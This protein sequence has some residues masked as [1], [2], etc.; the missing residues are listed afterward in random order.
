MRRT[1]YE[2]HVSLKYVVSF[3]NFLMKQMTHRRLGIFKRKCGVCLSSSL[4]ISVPALLM[5]LTSSDFGSGINWAINSVRNI[6][7]KQIH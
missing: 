7:I 3:L 5:D 4:N 6:F 2:G 1:G